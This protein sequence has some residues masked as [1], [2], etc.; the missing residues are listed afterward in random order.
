[1][2]CI[3][4]WLEGSLQLVNPS[5]SLV[6]PGDSRVTQD[7]GYE[8][9]DHMDANPNIEAFGDGWLRLENWHSLVDSFCFVIFLTCLDMSCISG[10]KH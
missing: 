8:F 1:M 7:P 9:R 2:V 10:K 5:E 3:S 4:A 6:N